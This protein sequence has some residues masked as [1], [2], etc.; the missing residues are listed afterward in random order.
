METPA[1]I[2]RNGKRKKIKIPRL[3]IRKILVPIDF[4]SHS[5]QVMKYAP[6]IA[7]SFNATIILMSVTDTFNVVDRRQPIQPAHQKERKPVRAYSA[8]LGNETLG[9]KNVDSF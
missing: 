2:A 7:K 8:C 4:P 6:A 3:S 9:R 1:N 5:S